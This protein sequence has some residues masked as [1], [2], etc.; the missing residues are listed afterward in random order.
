MWQI[1]SHRLAASELFTS[2]PSIRQVVTLRGQPDAEH[3][4]SFSVAADRE[5][6]LANRRR[7]CNLLGFSPELL[8]VP[9]C[10][11]GSEVA[12]ISSEDDAIGMHRAIPGCDAVIT[13][14][15]GVL[16]HLTAADCLPVFFHDPV[17]QAIG[18]AHSGWRGTAGRIVINTLNRMGET[19]GTRAETCL[20]AVGPGISA[21]GYEVD[22][23][24]YCAFLP[25]DADSPGVFTPSRPG[26]W[27]LDLTAAVLHQ[28]RSLNVPETNIDVSLWRTDRGNS[29][30]YSHRLVNRCP[31]MGAFLGLLPLPR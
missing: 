9:A 8:A 26:H 18:L 25:S 23:R 29:L 20:V 7:M 4:F 16:L 17:H 24:V 10:V 30:F 11:H 2:F 13:D 3:N 22:D 14:R 27:Q 6:V 21:E 28:L 5:Q 31:R 15:P 19:F 1:T 12:L